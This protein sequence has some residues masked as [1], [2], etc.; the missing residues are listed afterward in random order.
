MLSDLQAAGKTLAIATSKLVSTAELVVAH[1]GIARHFVAVSGAAP[2]G[3]R[4]NKSDIVAHALS[5][6][7][8]PDPAGVAMVG[9]RDGDMYAAIE[10]GLAPLGAGWGYGSAEELQRAGARW[11]VES[12]QR[13]AELVAPAGCPGALGH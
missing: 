10:H 1:F 7:G 5:N 12:P 3:T 4:T 11:V 2:N 13:L 9:D 6:L 8:W